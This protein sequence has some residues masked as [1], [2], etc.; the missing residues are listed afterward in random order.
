MK[1]FYERNGIAI[2][3]GDCLKIMPKLDGPFDAIIADWPY[4]TTACAWDSVIPLEP[5][6]RECKRLS[7]LAVL[8]GSQ[9]FTSELVMSNLEWFKYSLVWEK[10][11]GT[12]PML[13]K[14][15]PLRKHEDILIF[16]SKQ[17][18]YNPQMITGPPYR[19]IARESGLDAINKGARGRKKA[20][21]NKG[22]RYPS[23]VLRFSNGNN[24]SVHP[25]QK[26]EPLM[27]YLVRTYTNPGDII[28]DN[29]MGSGTTL[30]AAQNEGRRATGIELSEEYCRVAVDRLRQPSFWSI[31]EKPPAPEQVDLETM[32]ER[33]L[34]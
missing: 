5:L 6:W 17:P 1:P 8:F 2:Y 28:L 11:L 12:N 21:D 18:V 16:Y 9:P 32:I 23:S 7:N 3:A 26:P 33:G 29:T 24:K 19:D 10:T 13:A 34:E 20:I 25:T 14:K 15:Q 27:A 31:R 4:G 30:V 22:T